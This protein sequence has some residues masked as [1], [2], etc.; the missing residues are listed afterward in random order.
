MVR[1][2]S[3]GV[4]LCQMSLDHNLSSHH[5]TLSIYENHQIP[6]LKWDHYHQTDNIRLMETFRIDFILLSVSARITAYITTLLQH[7]EGGSDPGLINILLSRFPQPALMPTRLRTRIN[8]RASSIVD[9]G[10]MWLGSELFAWESWL[11]VDCQVS[12][13]QGSENLCQLSILSSRL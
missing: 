1:A 11:I 8:S 10:F 5:Q 6:V 9:P 3:L 4:T 12:S 2:R 7:R 13:W